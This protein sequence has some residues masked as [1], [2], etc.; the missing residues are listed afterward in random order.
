MDIFYI[1]IEQMKTPAVNILKQDALSIGAELAV[2]AGVI[3]CEREY[4]DCLLIGTKRQLEKLAKKELA[5]PFGLKTLGAK[6]KEILSEKEFDTK[7]MGVINANSDSFYSGS[8][9]AGKEAVAQI[10]QMIVDGADIID[11][12]GVSSRPGSETV[13]WQEELARV[14]D[15]IDIC[16]E[17]RLYE[18]AVFSLDSYSPE[19][20]EYALES[21]FTFINDITGARDS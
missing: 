12:G 19:V 18:K 10:E 15:I 5:Q 14:K 2:P 16:K 4:Y 20:I 13:P 6:L 1:Q 7:I 9:F 17:H 11:I 8:R 3:L 21:G